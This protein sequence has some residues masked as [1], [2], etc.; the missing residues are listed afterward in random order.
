MW[1]G[2][3][4]LEPAGHGVLCGRAVV[5]FGGLVVVLAAPVFGFLNCLPTRLSPGIA[6]GKGR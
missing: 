6:K 5:I 2:R 3:G 4:A 1:V